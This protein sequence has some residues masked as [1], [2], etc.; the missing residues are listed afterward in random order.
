MES[1]AVLDVR[2]LSIH[3]KQDISG[4]TTDSLSVYFLMY[5]A[6]LCYRQS[7]CLRDNWAIGDG[8]FLSDQNITG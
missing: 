6:V 7:N 4:L 2:S 3:N 8:W 1:L 5:M